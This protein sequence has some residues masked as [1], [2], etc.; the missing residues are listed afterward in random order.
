MKTLNHLSNRSNI[1][2]YKGRCQLLFTFTK[3][4]WKIKALLKKNYYLLQ[5]LLLLPPDA[6]RLSK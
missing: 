1:V 4:I 6:T 2:E 3:Q 5:N